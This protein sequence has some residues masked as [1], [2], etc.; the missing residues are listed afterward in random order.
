MEDWLFLKKVIV[1][2]RSFLHSYT[3]VLESVEGTHDAFLVTA[4]GISF[5][6]GDVVV[7][8]GVEN[9]VDAAVEVISDVVVGVVVVVVVGVVFGVVVV[10]VL[11]GVVVEDVV[12]GVVA[13]F[14]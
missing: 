3:H 1:Y 4:M 5:G 2:L 7:V 9:D 12:V 11:V 6:T 14:V 8:V 13:G 10:G